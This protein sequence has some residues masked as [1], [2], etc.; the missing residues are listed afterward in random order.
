MK[1][2]DFY[3]T[4][5]D[6]REWTDEQKTRWQEK[7]FELGFSWGCGIGGVEN[8]H[9]TYYLLE[10]SKEIT[11]LEISNRESFLVNGAKQMFFEDM[12]PS[13]NSEQPAHALDVVA[14]IV[15]QVNLRKQQLE[16]EEDDR[17]FEGLIYVEPDNQW[18]CLV[19]SKLTEDQKK[20]IFEEL[21][22]DESPLT[23]SYPKISFVGSSWTT[24]YGID[25]QRE[26]TFNDLFQ[27]KENLND[28]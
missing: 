22:C 4:K 17:G 26:V 18:D 11:F 21:V 2:E 12:F 25:G 23:T 24:G 14:A 1:K 10:D 7:C 28:L 5:W 9:A 15:E 3:F 19:L 16:C 8:L 6:A 20:F 27:Y 13:E